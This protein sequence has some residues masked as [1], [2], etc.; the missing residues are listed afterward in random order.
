MRF[1]APLIEARL[2]RRYKR[3][4]AD[5]E[6]GDGSL[7]TAHCPNP[8]AMLGLAVPGARALVSETRSP[9]RKLAFSWELV[10]A[11]LPGGR[12]WVGI[13]TMRPN[14]LVA[15]AFA[16]GSLPVPGGYTV[17]RPEVRYAQASRV[18]FLATGEGM[19]PCHVEV[20]NCHLMRRAGLAEF[21]DCVAARSARHMADLAAVVEAGGRA[22]V[23]IVVQMWADRFD[24]A[25]D[26]DPAFDRAFQAARAA[27]VAVHAHRC[28]IGPGG[29]T[30]ADAI[31]VL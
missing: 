31:P 15:E 24:V 18:D 5:M 12:Q 9:T 27:G 6:L 29:I 25:R 2:V 19:L 30:I 22:M 26:L 23:V 10:E 13:N 3:F 17:L 8:G 1:S 11:D 20:K 21:P 28:R 16:D 14:A 7:V 4:L